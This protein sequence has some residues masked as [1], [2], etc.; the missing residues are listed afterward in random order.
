M[1]RILRCALDPHGS[2]LVGWLRRRLGLGSA[3]RGCS[4]EPRGASLGSLGRWC[5]DPLQPP[6]GGLTHNPI[7]DQPSV[8][9]EALYGRLGQWPETP[10]DRPRALARPT[11][12]LLE[13]PHAG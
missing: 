13:S 10:V 7:H 8:V 5:D 4:F 1:I 12:S 11:Q 6:A 3:L 9:L 2:G